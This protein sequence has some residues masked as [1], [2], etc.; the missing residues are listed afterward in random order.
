MPERH[1]HRDKRVQAS[2]HPEKVSAPPDSFPIP[3]IV[4]LMNVDS[5]RAH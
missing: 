4:E 3:P 1:F 5:E 2:N